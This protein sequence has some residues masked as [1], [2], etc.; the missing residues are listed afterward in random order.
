V[1]AAAESTTT[2]APS[3]TA[4][5]TTTDAPTTTR[6]PTTTAAPTTPAPT[7]AAPT[8]AAP[9]TA[10]PTTT[11]PPAPEP[12]GGS[13]APVS[14][15][16]SSVSCPSGGSI[17]V[18]SSIASNL[19]AMVRAAAGSGVMLCGG[20]YRSSD[21]QIAL[22]R[23]NC[24]SSY[25]DIYQRPSSQCSPPTAPPGSSMHE[26]GLAIDF[27]CNGGGAIGSRSGP[28]FQWLSANASSFG[29][30]NLPSEPWHWSTSGQ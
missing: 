12:T 14:G 11:A 15:S 10:A 28:C 3:T 9:T 24:G 22:R 23:Q 2:E 27:T 17:T 4:E 6:A 19:G 20:G 1:R 5:T 8:T 30:Y 25:Y 26:Q 29:F 16:L 13:I 18:S 21:S 7:T